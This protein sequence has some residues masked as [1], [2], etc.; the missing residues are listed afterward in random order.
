MLK[1]VIFDFD[2]V[3]ADSEHLHWKAAHEVFAAIGVEV[4]WEKYYAD[5]LAYTDTECFEAIIRDYHLSLT[6]KE[7][8]ELICRKTTA[9]ERVARAESTLIDGVADFIE[10]LKANGIRLAICSGA[11][12]N[13]IEVMLEDSELLQAFEVVVTADDTTRGKPDPEGYL[14]TLSRLNTPEKSLNAGECVVIED[15]HG[16]L[17]AARA[18]NMRCVAVSNTYSADDLAGHAD[19]IVNHLGDISIEDLTL[20]I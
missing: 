12:L 4:P 3:I 7:M 13:D 20:L 10:M 11:C 1:A 9:F 2:G 17:Q 6:D 5:Y 14:F 15:S 16:G 19:L 18:A 8:D